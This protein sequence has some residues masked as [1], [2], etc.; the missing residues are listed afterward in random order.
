MTP[1]TLGNTTPGRELR[2]RFLWLGLAMTV[3]LG[4]LS[5]QLYRLQI[6]R[7]EEYSAK[8]V[9]N[10]VK[11][12]RLRADRGVIKDARGTILVDSR[13]S[14]DA[15]VTPAFCTDCSEQV[16][17]R[18]AELLQ[19]DA[20]QA[21]KVE[22]LV[23]Q[24]RRNA[25]FQPVPVRVDLTRDEY[26]RLA[27][28]R[29]ILD[30]VEVA[31]VPHRHYRTNTVLSH[32]LGYMN[33]ITQEELERLNGDGS[34]YALGDY[35][36]RRG[37]ERYFEQRLRGQDGVRKEVVNARGQKI[38][39]LNVKLGDNAVVQPQAG[40]N[41]VLSIDMRLQEEAE[42]A[43]PG[44]TGAVVAIDVH[45]GFIRALVSRPGFDPNL[46]TGRVTPTQMAQLSRD[47]LEPMVNRVA[48]EHYSPGSTFKV[49]TALAAFKSGAFRPETVV[50]CPGGYR[51]GART[52]RCHLDRG[53]GP[54]NGLD[55]MKSSCDTW[56]Y[57]VA[58]T[59]GLD[60]I[61]EMGKSL[62]LGSPTGISVVAEV[63]GIMPTSA[64]HD[65]A[66]PG[67]YTKGMALN[68]A[69]G[70]GDNNVTPLQLALMY[71]AIANGGTLYKPQMVQRLENLDGQ[72]VQEFKPEVV[73][74]VE[75]PPAHLKSVIEGLVKVAHE[76]GGTSYRSRLKGMRDL[77]VL[78]AAKTGTAQVARLGAI[79]L[80]THQMSYF[81]RDHAWF[82]GFAP[83]DKP[84]IAV[85]VLNEHG[86]HGG[87]DAAPTAM[88]VIQKYLDL[89][90]LD[91]SAPPPRPNQPYTPSV[92]RAPSP[93]EAALT[94]GVKPPKLLPGD[95]EA[96]EDT[97][98]T[99]D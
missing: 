39:E 22:D 37:L 35:I 68:S 46:L 61:G 83:A 72:V 16:I 29:D 70:Q 18:L 36:G 96:L 66:S 7:G 53:H 59:I 42:R 74:R 31:P 90:K 56:F 8:S 52:W 6:T 79:R 9:A 54:V 86:G 82:A 60:P 71:A 98:A 94:R 63:P 27:A 62:G 76:P 21:K 20:D 23:R 85:V 73:R 25:P 30:G 75:L 28:R 32:V 5:I 19:W 69:I 99:P 91:A 87:V 97:H 41:L 77:D 80:R 38:E 43:F 65:K 64:Y 33:E 3:L 1:P 47:P 67:G 48:A 15:V 89:K 45:T 10:F 88:A 81:E 92:L 13:P 14:F 84:E 17:P 78:V 11:E 34:R 49:V 24:G 57:K 50:N 12:V 55:A 58:D 95:E 44:V 93:D 40:S 4:V 26:D 2:R 51:L